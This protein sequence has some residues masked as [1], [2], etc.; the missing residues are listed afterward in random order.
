MNP[1]RPVT[2]A[3]SPVRAVAETRSRPTTKAILDPASGEGANRQMGR[4][5]S[6]WARHYSRL[7]AL[8]ADFEAE[9]RD[10]LLATRQPLEPYSLDMADAATDEFDHDLAL[11]VLSAEQNALYEID[12]ALK[13]IRTG[14][15]GVC[16]L[17]GKPIPQ[18]R[19]DA[20]PWTRF[21]GEVER[22]L[23]MEGAASRPHLG[24]LRS[25]T[26]L[27]AGKLGEVEVGEEEPGPSA[28]DESLSRASPTPGTDLSD[29]RRSKK[30]KNS[31]SAFIQSLRASKSNGRHQ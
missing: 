6:K 3:E 26:G 13:R 23:E 25:V 10:H 4:V 22:Q 18:A 16:E 15:Y 31:H 28:S 20:L 9:Y 1:S 29:R 19:L 17:S 12:E 21:A 14:S 27:P 30:V 8:R 5:P 2:K 11:C 7:L 24:E